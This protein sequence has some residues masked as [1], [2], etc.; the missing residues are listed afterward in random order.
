MSAA[1]KETAVRGDA[2]AATE[3]KLNGLHFTAPAHRQQALAA[4]DHLRVPLIRGAKALNADPELLDIRPL[5]MRTSPAADPANARAKLEGNAIMACNE[6]VAQRKGFKPTRMAL[7]ITDLDEGN[8][9]LDDCRFAISDFFGSESIACV[10]STSSSCPSSRRWRLIVPLAQAV[11]VAVWMQVQR[12]FGVYLESVKIKADPCME[13]RATQLSFL[14][15]VPPE[16]RHPAG[17]VDP[18]TGEDLSGKPFHF[19]HAYWGTALFDPAAV[20]TQAAAVGLRQLAE[21]DAAEAE[22]QRQRHEAAERKASERAAERALALA[23]G[24]DG[25]SIV[26]RFN[27]TNDTAA[28]LLQYDYTQSPEKPT[29]WR[30]PMQKSGTYATRLHDDG[31]WFSL[32]GSDAAAGLGS[33]MKGGVGGDA[34]DLYVHF[35]HGGNYG[36]A[37]ASLAPKAD[38]GVF[39]GEPMPEGFGPADVLIPFGGAPGG[40]KRYKLQTPAEFMSRPPAEWALKDIMPKRGVMTVYGQ[41]GSGKTFLVLDLLL[42]LLDPLRDEWCGERIRNRPSAVVYLALEGAWREVT[43]EGLGTGQRR[44]SCVR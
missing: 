1:Q 17:V 12:A 43:V 14:P 9:T 5:F 32:S 26:E 27:A 4:A 7:C 24:G 2:T 23:N 35:A 30:S 21:R 10:Y 19:E 13:D 25:M 6:P 34:F 29:D 20:P 38:V 41:S 8:L 37:V 15:N 33:P 22:A 31:S 36:K 18:F 42:T 28:L 40:V 39:T 3:T 11:S 44:P 16:G